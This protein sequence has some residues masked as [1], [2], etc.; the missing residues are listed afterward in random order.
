[1]PDARALVFINRLCVSIF[2]KCANVLITP[3]M[4]QCPVSPLSPGDTLT[5]RVSQSEASSD[6]GDQS[7]ASWGET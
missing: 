2:I 3:L 7:E 4:S 6:S 1:M 5:L